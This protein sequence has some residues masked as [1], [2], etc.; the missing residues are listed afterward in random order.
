MIVLPAY[1]VQAGII[2]WWISTIF[3]TIKKL[4][5]ILFGFMYYL[6]LGMGLSSICSICLNM[7]SVLKHHAM[8]VVCD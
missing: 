2:T 4:L 8:R 1:I 3:L 7:K 6:N 5:D